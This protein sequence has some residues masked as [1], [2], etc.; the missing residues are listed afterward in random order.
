MSVEAESQQAAP[1]RWHL[2]YSHCIT[3]TQFR[4]ETMAAK[5]SVPPP[6]YHG[7]E[8]TD[9]IA[10]PAHLYYLAS[11]ACQAFA[12]KGSSDL[13]REEGLGRQLRARQTY[14]WQIQVR[15][16]QPLVVSVYK[17]D[18]PT[19][20]GDM[21]TIELTVHLRDENCQ[22]VARMVLTYQVNT[23]V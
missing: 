18:G 1:L 20:I 8:G 22:S 7:E 11:L 6:C 23:Q 3:D 14:N 12:D 19:I 21:I 15:K 4:G 16:G 2:E 9:Q 13:L 17:S 10:E 5:G